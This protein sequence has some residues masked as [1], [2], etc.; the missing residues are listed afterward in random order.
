MTSHVRRRAPEPPSAPAPELLPV[1]AANVARL[2]SARNLSLEELAARVQ[3]PPRSLSAIE[4]GDEL[5]SL[6]TLWSLANGLDVTFGELIRPQGNE[7][8]PA[9]APK[10]SRRSLLPSI[11]GRHQTD[12]HE[13]TLAPRSEAVAPAG[14][15]HTTESLLLTAGELVVSYQGQSHVLTVGEEFVIPAS[16][17]RRYANPSDQTTVIYAKI[18][19]S[20]LA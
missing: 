19:Q 3:L 7:P 14:D 16:V 8:E 5:P 11:P 12:L 15:P 20:G 1:I 13:M 10:L 18:R 6:D 4:R 9:R 2:R 17:E